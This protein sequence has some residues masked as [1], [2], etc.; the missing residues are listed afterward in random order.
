MRVLQV[1]DSYPPPVA[2]GR[3]LHVQMLAHE[4][5]ARGHEVEVLTLAG[6]GRAGE[7]RDGGI[8]VHRVA[9]WSR[10]LGR[11]YA[12]PRH[13]VHPTVPDPGLV[14]AAAAL[15]R[16]LRPDI[17]HAHSWAVHSLLPLLPSAETG[18]VMTLHDYG[19][20]CPKTT[21]V[22]G[23]SVCSGPEFVKCVRCASGQYGPARALAVTSG[24]N[25]M[26]P[27]HR[28]VDR[29]IAVSRAVA[30][31]CAALG[32]SGRPPI[33]VIPPFLADGSLA[34]GGRRRPAFVPATGRYV[35][36]A[37]AMS[38]HKGL[39]VLLSAWAAM[40][41]R[42]P[43]VLA[44]I[45]RHDTPVRFPDGVIV[46]ENVPHEEVLAAFAHCSIAVVP[47]LWPDPM[48][49]VALEA[50]AAGRPVVASAVGGLAELFAGGS[51][52][53]LVPPGDSSA[54][55][56]AMRR[57]LAAPTARARLAEAA[58]EQAA[59]F[60]ASRV[61]PR[62]ERVYDAVTGFRRRAR[63]RPPSEAAIVRPPRLTEND[64]GDNP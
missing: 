5:V 3:E 40:E 50:L 2:G 7:D 28:R 32:G 37:G 27:L 39:D 44:G 38:P 31:A 1:V 52:G 11:F 22:H 6:P 63:R 25:S 21:F 48:P 34:R 30:Q 42:V 56:E 13:P 51:A 35:M 16:R 41:R 61:V 45:R 62:L 54:L 17:V 8:P 9:G 23:S 60:S 15:V 43:L 36:F 58:S 26:R 33:E 64:P 53:V 46:A 57:L 49:L 10:A 20:V 24:L 12:D 59:A 18:L 29:Y 19:M 4:L 14:R 47:S 55:S